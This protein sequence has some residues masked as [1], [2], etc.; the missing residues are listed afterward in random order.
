MGKKGI[1]GLAV[2][3]A[4]CLIGLLVLSSTIVPSK[5]SSTETAGT[6]EASSGET[7]ATPE[8]AGA[9]EE[10]AEGEVIDSQESAELPTEEPEATESADKAS[11]K[12]S[13]KN[14]SDSDKKAS[15]KDAKAASDKKSTSNNKSSSKKNNSEKNNNSSNK[16]GGGA[17]TDSSN[18]GGGSNN[19]SGGNSST[20]D[21]GTNSSE[22]Q[23]DTPKEE[24]N[25]KAALDG[26]TITSKDAECTVSGSKATITKAGTY[27]FSG[28]LS[29]GQ[30]IVDTEKTSKV[31]IICQ[32]MSLNCSN[33]APLYIKSADAVTLQLAAG[34]S[35][36]ITDGTSYAFDTA[37]KEPDAALYSDE[38]LTIEGSGSLTITGKYQDGIASKNDIEIKQGTL[39]VTAADDG[40]R[41]KDGIKISGGTVKVISES[42]ALK[43]TETVQSGAGNVEISGGEVSLDAVGDGIHATNQIKV[44]GGNTYIDAKNEG[45]DTD[46]SF[47]MT[48]GTMVI[49]GTKSSNHSIFD[50]PKGAV[51]NGGVFFAVGNAALSKPLSGSGTQKSLFFKA[52]TEQPTDTVVKIE[53]SSGKTKY[54][55]KATRKYQ[56]VIFSAPS[57]SAGN[58][59]IYQGNIK[60][61]TTK[62]S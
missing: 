31:V 30:V 60:L 34:T 5:D 36:S 27:T 9:E 62:V 43:T 23:Q 55:H 7:A 17:G 57:L 40:I 14:T 26:L 46:T 51:V 19:S 29:N 18:S 28:K 41:G 15:D 59:N 3:G 35:N 44:A 1:I 10:S 32:S 13:K 58:Y 20:G 45:L 25:Y 42:H 47:L 16:D 24:K 52:S 61:G 8:Q 54:Q 12:N 53:D 37:V 33:S 56:C 22:N 2:A 48:A 50:C 4:I 38:D 21:S 49:D 6:M 11:K 39:Q